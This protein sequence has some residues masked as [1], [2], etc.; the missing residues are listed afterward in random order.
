MICPIHFAKEIETMHASDP[1]DAPD[2][3]LATLRKME[4]VK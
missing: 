2:I 4:A 3:K 1:T